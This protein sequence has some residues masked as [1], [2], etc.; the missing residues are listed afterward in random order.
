[1]SI[2]IAVHFLM[3]QVYNHPNISVFASITSLALWLLVRRPGDIPPNPW[4]IFP[5]LGHRPLLRGDPITVL[6]RLRKELGDVYSIYVDAQLVIVVNGFAAIKEAFFIRGDEFHWRPNTRICDLFHFGVICNSGR[7]WREQRK[8]TEEGILH[9]KS[10]VQPLVTKEAANLVDAIKE[11]KGEATDFRELLHGAV[12]NALTSIIFSRR[13]EYSDVRLENVFTRF[14]ENAELFSDTK[15]PNF[16]PFQKFL[17]GDFFD[18]KFLRINMSEIHQKVISPVFEE[19]KEEYNDQKLV[20]FLD[21]YLKEMQLKKDVKGTTVEEKSCQAVIYDLLWHGTTTTAATLQWAFVFLLGNSEVRDKLREELNRH[22]AASSVNGTDDEVR[23]NVE[24]P[25]YFQAFLYEVMRCANVCQISMAH[26]V[27]KEKFLKGYRVPG[28]AVILPNLDSLMMDPDLWTD[29]FVFQPQRF[30]KTDGRLS[31]PVEF[32]PFFLGI[33]G[34]PASDMAHVI[35][36]SFLATILLNFD[37]EP[38]I[39]GQPPSTTRQKG[40]L[41]LPKDFK[42]KLVPR[43]Q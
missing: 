1:M 20:D 13:M 30:I 11:K 34:C 35:L 14:K 29:P 8:V 38:E 43:Q 41:P 24:L 42:S 26:A 33:R 23:V 25:I 4:F 31:V 16:F 9:T 39:E 17:L 27:A 36:S 10:H 22:H 12:F 7:E 37:L 15:F 40:L 6:R 21:I 18:V 5:F 3:D 28:D 2:Y 19:H 32:I